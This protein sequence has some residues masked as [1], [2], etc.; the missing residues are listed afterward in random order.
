MIEFRRTKVALLTVAIVTGCAGGS[1]LPVGGPGFGSASV[2]IPDTALPVCKAQKKTKKYASVTETLNANGGSLCIPRFGAFGGTLNVPLATLADKV[3]LTS[4]TTNYA[5]VPAPKASGSPIFYLNIAPASVT[6][7]GARLKA[8]GGLTGKGIK[9]KKT[10]TGYLEGYAFSSW[11]ALTD[12][13]GLATS[14]KYGG[15]KC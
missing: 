10:Y 5:S 1:Q 14:G 3:T 11:R 13:Y 6:T 4:S 9:A 15:T 2:L 8:G 12:C 7:F